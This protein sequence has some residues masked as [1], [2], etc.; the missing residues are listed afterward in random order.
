MSQCIC[1]QQGGRSTV[2]DFVE[3]TPL[4][5][6]FKHCCNAY[7]T[8]FAATSEERLL[9]LESMPPPP[10]VFRS[11]EDSTACKY[12]VIFLLTCMFSIV[13]VN[14]TMHL[15]AARWMIDCL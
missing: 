11:D 5:Y 12:Y 7:V 10:E 13:D 2:F 1:L 9:V 6:I 3:T 15:F 14:V 4:S 8:L